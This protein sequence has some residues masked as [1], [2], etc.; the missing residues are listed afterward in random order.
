[1]IFIAIYAVRKKQPSW[2]A[3]V[4]G[5]NPTVGCNKGLHC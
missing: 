3:V 4:V 5:A 1:M 2:E